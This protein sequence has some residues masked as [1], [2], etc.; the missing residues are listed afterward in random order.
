MNK[1]ISIALLLLVLIS[2]EDQVKFNNSALQGLKDNVVWRATL[3]TAEQSADGSLK[4]MA[5]QKNEI[6]TLTTASANVQTY[7]LGKN[8]S[9]RVVL[10]QKGT[11]ATVTFSTGIESGN[12]KIVITELNTVNH[13]ITGEFNFN[14]NNES[15]DP[16]SEPSVSFQKG[17][18]YKVTLTN[19]VKK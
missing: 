7:T 14:A 12:G 10:S 17:I 18:F 4:I 5:Y 11:D 2:C 3:I 15:K 9:N 13:T 16:I 8:L 1:L 6:L 19:T